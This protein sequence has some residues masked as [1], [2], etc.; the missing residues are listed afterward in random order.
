M[1]YAKG[2]KIA[3]AREELQKMLRMSPESSDA[4]DARKQLSQLAS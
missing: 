2:G 4:Q 1:A 3:N